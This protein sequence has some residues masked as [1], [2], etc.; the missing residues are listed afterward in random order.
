MVNLKHWLGI[1]AMCLMALSVNAYGGSKNFGDYEVHYS[2]SRA[3]SSAPR[4]PR[5]TT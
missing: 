4:W 2:V 1:A 5:R 3:R